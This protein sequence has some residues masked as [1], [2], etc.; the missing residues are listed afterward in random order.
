MAALAINHWR[1]SKRADLSGDE[2]RAL[3]EVHSLD[4]EAREEEVARMLSG[5][6]VT[7]EARAAAAKLIGGQA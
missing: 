1:I 7:E 3:T 6:S 4:V 5:A 2:E